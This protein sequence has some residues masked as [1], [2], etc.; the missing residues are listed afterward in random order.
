MQ[1]KKQ[2]L[3]ESFANTAFGFGISFAS[4]FLIF[5]LLDIVTSPS[6]NLVITAYFTVVSILRSYFVRR[7]FNKLIN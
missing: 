3:I 6:A 5:P 4:T 1:T 7:W 2:S